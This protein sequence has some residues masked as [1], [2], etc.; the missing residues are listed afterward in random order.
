M[1]EKLI[2]PDELR[3]VMFNVTSMN[4]TY[5]KACE[6]ISQICRDRALIID[7]VVVLKGTFYCAKKMLMA[8]DVIGCEKQCDSCI[9][10]DKQ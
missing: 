5:G 7:S 2:K 1:T 3:E 10:C 6:Q 4:I 9:R 8:N